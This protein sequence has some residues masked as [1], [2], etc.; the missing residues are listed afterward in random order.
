M[1]KTKAVLATMLI[2]SL[3]IVSSSGV[4]AKNNAIINE[5]ISINETNIRLLGDPAPKGD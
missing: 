2:C 5:N 4:W 3:L 1:K